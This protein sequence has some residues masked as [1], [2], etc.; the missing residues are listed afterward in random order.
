MLSLRLEDAYLPRADVLWSLRL[1]G[2]QAEALATVTGATVS[3]LRD[4]PVVGI[5]IQ[6]TTP[7]T[8]TM[9]ADVANIAALG[10]RVGLLV[11]SEAGERGIYRRAART[12]RTLRRSFGDLTV[13]PVEAGWLDELA[14]RT[15]PTQFAPIPPRAIRTPAGGETLEWSLSTRA[16]LRELG[17]RAGFIVAEPYVPDLLA[18]AFQHEQGRASP[19]AHLHDPVARKSARMTKTGDY[20]TACQV[21]LAWLLQLPSG[22]HDFLAELGTL[23]PHLREHGMLYPE[24]YRQVA[25]VGFELE[26]SG[27]KHA[28]GG[29]LTLSAYCVMGIGVSPTAA[30]AAQLEAILARYR[31]TLGLRNVRVL[32]HA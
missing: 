19:L 15:W 5:E 22:L 18:V 17:Q 26:S 8:K 7:S 9:V 4:L 14:R 25:V 10:T 24:L 2:R 6:G 3:L 27:G 31:P 1:S 23:D 28:A 13:L 12:I 16:Y 20:L 21:D 30:G 11:V 29:L 32:A